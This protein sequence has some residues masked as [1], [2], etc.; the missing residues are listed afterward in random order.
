MA[1]AKLCKA[2]GNHKRDC[3]VYI[4][5]NTKLGLPF[6]MAR[7]R[8]LLTQRGRSPTVATAEGR[9]KGFESGELVARNQSSKLP[10]R[11]SPRSQRRRRPLTLLAPPPAIRCLGH[12]P[13]PPEGHRNYGQAPARLSV[14]IQLARLTTVVFTMESSGIYGVIDRLLN[15]DRAP[16][17]TP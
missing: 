7:A 15:P 16:K 10:R 14:R 3:S 4:A 6:E 5:K 9:S 13:F 1:M 8:L 12:V 2:L 17:P 11:L